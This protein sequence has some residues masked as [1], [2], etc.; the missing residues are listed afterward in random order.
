MKR[1]HLLGFPVTTQP[2]CGRVQNNYL[3]AMADQYVDCKACK[4]ILRE[5]KK[6]RNKKAGGSK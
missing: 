1:A 5:R 6:L 4:E 3:V 2:A